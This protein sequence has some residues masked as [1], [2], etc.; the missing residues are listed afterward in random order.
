MIVALAGGVGAAKF[1]RGL[2]RIVDPADVTVIVNTADDITLH[3]L[4]ISPDVDTIVYSLAGAADRERGW[5]LAGESWQCLTA[6]ERYDMATWFQIGDRDLATHLFRTKR[7]DD[8][9]ELGEITA[10][11]AR[12]WGLEVRV[13]PMSDDRVE[14]RIVVEIDDKRVDLHFQEYLIE[15]RCA[16]PV[17]DVSYRGI[18]AAKPNGD[19]LMAL[20][21]ADAIVICPSNPVVS[22][23]PILA[24][25]RYRY[26]LEQRRARCVAVS[27]LVGGAPVRGPADKL[28]AAVGLEVSNLGVVEAYQGIIDHVVIDS[29][30]AADREPIE[31]RGVATTT[32]DT[33]MS[34]TD[35]AVRVARSVIEALN[36]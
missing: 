15:R 35:D 18:D 13:L 10:E 27:P 34:T 33:L 17:V 8:G 36:A 24:F 1:L 31:R 2:V 7:Y 32:T 16:D 29:G 26:A 19:A 4:R 25:D 9:L 5:G 6:L 3:G 11:I 30:D 22:I 28:M 21:T 14:N 20:E 12:R 23:G